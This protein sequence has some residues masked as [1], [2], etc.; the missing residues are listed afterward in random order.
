MPYPESV[1]VLTILVPLA[2]ALVS[3][4]FRW[5]TLDRRV[6]GHLALLKDMPDEVNA[7]KLRALVEQELA[8]LA[9]LN[10][11]RLHKRHDRMILFM[12]LFGSAFAAGVAVLFYLY[13]M[14]KDTTWEILVPLLWIYG[15]LF[16][17]AAGYW[18]MGIGLRIGKRRAAQQN[19]P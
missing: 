6:K 5:P 2:V 17:L 8:E 9:R 4:P 11:H 12:R 18:L 14:D 13:S 1:Q 16:L 19:T 3:A 15:V 10:R 7:A